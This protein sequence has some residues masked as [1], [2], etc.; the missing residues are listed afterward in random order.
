[1]AI[2][3]KGEATSAG[4][5]MFSL[6]RSGF[7]GCH[8]TLLYD[9]QKNGCE[10]DYTMFFCPLC[11]FVVVY[12]F[13]LRYSRGVTYATPNENIVQNHLKFALLDVF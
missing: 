4:H 3:P 8:A 2:A 9:I 7:L 11:Q 13:P 6:L 1:M 5:I 12:T 10:G